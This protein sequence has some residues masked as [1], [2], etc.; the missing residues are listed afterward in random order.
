MPS[1]LRPVAGGYI[2]PF[3]REGRRTGDGDAGAPGGVRH[4]RPAQVAMEA[5]AMAGAAFLLPG[6]VNGY[7]RIEKRLDGIEGRR[8]AA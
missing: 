2:D 6:L 4:R 5:P 3:L 7:S 1:T 8:R